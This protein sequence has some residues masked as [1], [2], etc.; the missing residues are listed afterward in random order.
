MKRSLLILSIFF[1]SINCWS[2]TKKLVIRIDTIDFIDEDED[3]RDFELIVTNQGFANIGET[4]DSA[5]FHFK[6]HPQYYN[7]IFLRSDSSQLQIPLDGNEGYM[8]IR[9]LYYTD[10]DTLVIDFYRLYSNCNYTRTNCWTIYFL[11]D[12]IDV[13]GSLVVDT[14]RSNF[15]TETSQLDCLRQPPDTIQLRINNK[16]YSEQV[17]FEAEETGYTI[18]GN[19]SHRSIWGKEKHRFY[20]RQT[21]SYGINTV[22][23]YLKE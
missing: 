18:T 13:D 15:K 21:I 10:L 19:G 12:T 1:F 4:F 2:Q 20:N 17:N 11:D 7:T 3:F 5:E 8:E 16:L 9:D 22:T 23:I 6:K 14:I